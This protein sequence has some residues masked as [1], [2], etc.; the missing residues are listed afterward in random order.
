MFLLLNG[1]KRQSEPL[2]LRLDTSVL[3]D[4][5]S[6]AE[7]TEITHETLYSVKCGKRAKV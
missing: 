4:I 3:L 7:W 6:N 1:L 2:W 5:E